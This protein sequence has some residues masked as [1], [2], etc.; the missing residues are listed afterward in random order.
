MIYQTIKHRI[1]P[2]STFGWYTRPKKQRKTFL[3]TVVLIFIFS[4]LMFNVISKIYQHA[5]YTKNI[6]SETIARKY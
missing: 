5:K 6:E 1:D 3:W 4:F 2:I